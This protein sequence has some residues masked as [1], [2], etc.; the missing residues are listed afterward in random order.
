MVLSQTGAFYEIPLSCK[1]LF[2]VDCEKVDLF[3]RLSRTA[4]IYL[5][6]LLK[7]SYS[8]I[9]TARTHPALAPSIFIGK[10]ATLKPK[11]NGILSRFANLSK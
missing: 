7:G 4:V 10:T 9:A 8:I 1:R 11:G 6:I 5:E 2:T 3:K